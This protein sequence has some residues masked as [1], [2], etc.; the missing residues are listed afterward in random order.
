MGGIQIKD[1]SGTSPTVNT[2]ASGQA[3]AGAHPLSAV[4]AA[5]SIPAHNQLGLGGPPQSGCPIRVLV[6][7]KR[8]IRLDIQFDI[9]E[10]KRK[11]YEAG[12]YRLFFSGGS[13]YQ[14]QDQ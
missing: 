12:I 3:S 9:D 13:L 7:D 2:G 11:E 14:N 6:D 1:A 8:V 10:S 5:S 4:G